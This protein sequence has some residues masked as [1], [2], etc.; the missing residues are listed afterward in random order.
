MTEPTAP[1]PDKPKRE[2][3]LWMWLGVTAGAI[4]LFGFAQEVWQFGLAPV[5][6][7]LVAYYRAMMDFLFGWLWNLLPFEVWDWYKNI[8][9]CSTILCA[10]YLKAVRPDTEKLLGKASPLKGFVSYLLTMA[11]M[12]PAFGLTLLQLTMAFFASINRLLEVMNVL[13]RDP[14]YARGALYADYLLKVS[15]VLIAFF[16]VNAYGI[17]VT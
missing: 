1:H 11:L 14:E 3:S 13:P 4:S 16:A 17:S 6:V 10:I 8:V 7:D 9:G 15:F 12:I 2:I 5:M